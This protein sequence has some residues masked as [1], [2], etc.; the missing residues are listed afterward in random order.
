[1]NPLWRYQGHGVV[2][3]EDPWDESG[4]YTQNVT[5]VECV[6]K[7][8]DNDGVLVRCR[9]L[10]KIAKLK[11]EQ[12]VGYWAIQ[13][14]HFT[15][16]LLRKTLLPTGR[17]SCWSRSASRMSK[18]KRKSRLME[19]KNGI[20]RSGDSSLNLNTRMEKLN[21]GTWSQWTWRNWVSLYL[22]LII[23]TD[24][25]GVVHEYFVVFDQLDEELHSLHEISKI[26]LISIVRY[27]SGAPNATG[28]K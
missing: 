14:C 2:K 11:D 4:G 9:Y 3:R 13:K 25:I 24:L 10:A 12:D 16:H 18:C 23:V 27:A 5:S 26:I 22:S 28:R 15:T 20:S 19:K 8:H 7:N 1:M 17:R 6:K 21:R